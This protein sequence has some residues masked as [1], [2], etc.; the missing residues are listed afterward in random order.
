MYFKD[1]FAKHTCRMH[2]NTVNK[3]G[4]FQGDIFQRQIR[5][6]AVA[7]IAH[8]TADKADIGVGVQISGFFFQ[9]FRQG[10]VVMIH[11]R[12][13]FAASHVHQLVARA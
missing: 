9:T 13:V 8:L 1:A 4:L 3:Q 6:S 7:D 2:Q 12:K 5:Y 11:N 10:N